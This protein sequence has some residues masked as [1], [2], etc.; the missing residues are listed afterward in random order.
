M[1]NLAKGFPGSE[2]IWHPVLSIAFRSSAIDE[3]TTQKK[4]K[5]KF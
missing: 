4:S 2:G 1:Q 3:A 5:M